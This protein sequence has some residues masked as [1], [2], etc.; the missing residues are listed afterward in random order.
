MR[1]NHNDLLPF[2]WT[3]F[4]GVCYKKYKSVITTKKLMFKIRRFFRIAFTPITMM[5][6]PHSKS[7]PLK[8]RVP[9]AWL[10]TLS[11][12]WGFGMFYVLS[13]GVRTIEYS[14]MSRK[15]S[16]L[17]GQFLEMRTT[18]SSLEAAEGEFRRLF[19][20]KSKKMVLE[21]VSTNETGDLDPELL[22]KRMAD[23]MASVAEI[24]RYIK[25]ARNTYFAT[26][27]GWPAPGALSSGFGRR[28]DPKTGEQAFHSGLDI[29][30]PS[31]T[32]VKA[33]A[34]GI[35]SVSG[36]VGGNGNIVAIEHGH[37]FSTAYAHNMQNLV[38]VGQRVKRGDTIALSGATGRTTGPHVHYQVWKR[39]SPID[40]V[41]F[42]KEGS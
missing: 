6:V 29:R 19:S 3:Y 27:M 38:K 22:R 10:V 31:G 33:T 13:T 34:D 35:V 30:A 17:S 26:P 36:W 23:A 15:F 5:I 28:T 24:K 4:L 21:A 37:D 16:Y 32:P 1:K 39:G 11:V 2:F 41:S 7:R 25:E 9:L 42:L 14:E 18:I 40:P 8:L 12:L 20:L